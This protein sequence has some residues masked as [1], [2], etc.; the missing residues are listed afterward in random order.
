VN[1]SEF[2]DPFYRFGIPGF[3][4]V[5][6]PLG[7]SALQVYPNFEKVA[8]PLTPP[9]TGSSY[10]LT[11]ERGIPN[12]LVLQLQSL[13]NLGN[14]QLPTDNTP[15]LLSAAAVQP[16]DIRIE[17]ALFAQEG[18]FF[19]IPGYWF[20]TDPSDTRANYERSLQRPKGVASP[21]FPFY[22]EPLDIR[23]TIVGS[24]AENFTASLG[25]QTEWLRKWGWIPRRYGSSQL[26]IPQQ[27]QRYFHDGA[28]QYAVNLLMRYDPIFRNPIVNGQPLRVAYDSTQDP[29]GQHPGRLLPPIPR[30]P[31]CPKPI[32][33]GDIR[34]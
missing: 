18:S 21:E 33:A 8:F 4:A 27:H 34:P 17:A 31:V 2:A 3:P 13:A 7:R 14:Y 25:D 26:E 15:Y 10:Q 9:P 11:P 29:S 5:M 16:L 24:I 20:N 19:V 30:L 6:Y 23:I 22:G 32:Y 12:L 1:P 28:Q